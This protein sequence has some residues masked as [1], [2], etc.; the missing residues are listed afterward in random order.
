MKSIEI[1]ENVEKEMV[2]VGVQC[3]EV[4]VVKVESGTQHDQVEVME[5]ETQTIPQVLVLDQLSLTID[6]KSNSPFKNSSAP[7]KPL[8]AR[9]HNSQ[10]F[11]KLRTQNM[12]HRMSIQ[13]RSATALMSAQRL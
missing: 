2:D 10:F 3:G 6:E 7:F 12:K 1:I 4:E 13:C 8:S 9:T 5:N 11:Q